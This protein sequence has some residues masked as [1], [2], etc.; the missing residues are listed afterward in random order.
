MAANRVV[1][2]DIKEAIRRH[3]QSIPKV[4]SYY[5]RES[6]SKEYL[7]TGYSI[8]LLHE[9][10]VE[11]CTKNNQIPGK[12]HLYTKIFNE[13]FNI[14][15]KQPK[16][17]RCDICEAA[18]MN[19][20]ATTEASEQYSSH[21]K[22]KL[23]TKDERDK[24]RKNKDSFVVCFDL[25]KVF[26]LP[27]AE[28]SNFFSRR[29]LSVYHHTAHCAVDKKAYTA[30][31]N[32]G[33][34]GRS[35]NDI[36]SSVITVL[37]AI[38]KKHASDPRIKNMI[39]WSDSCV[40]QNQNSLLATA[41]KKF[42]KQHPEIESVQQKFCEPG[43]SSIQEVNNIHSQ[44]ERVCRHVEI[45]SPV[46]LMKLLKKVN[47]K[48]PISIT[49]MKPNMFKDYQTIAKVGQFHR[50]PFSKIKSLL[51]DN[52]EPKILKYK[53]S[54]SDE[55]TTVNVFDKNPTRLNGNRHF[56]LPT[57]KIAKH[58]SLSDE[59]I[60][61]IKAMLKFMPAS[62]KTYMRLVCNKPLLSETTS[63]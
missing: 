32:E 30:L 1:S 19:D 31:W 63:S 61:D 52:S 45:Y 16:K 24:D 25:Q 13:E 22:S 33:Q 17:D 8:T 59:K 9:E 5:C 54:F 3:I 60:S 43:H 36:A 47:G 53:L 18:K 39:L 12:L 46:G 6:S 14:A 44:V 10:Y 58:S 35:G 49:Q 37:E 62:D 4:Q 23:E 15:F 2:N 41:I 20:H 56:I 34:N 28:V 11:Q 26:S 7:P 55:W 21:L 29:K 38:V 40:P 50:I 51:Y 57:P 42:L 48:N 27:S